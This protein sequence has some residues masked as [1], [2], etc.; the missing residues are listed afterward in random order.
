MSSPRTVHS[1]QYTVHSTVHSTQ[2]QYTLHITQDTV[3]YT[4]SAELDVR[5]AGVNAS[6]VYCVLCTVLWLCHVRATEVVG[7]G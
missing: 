4:V 2:C 6:A 3:Q 7:F 1:T 5:N